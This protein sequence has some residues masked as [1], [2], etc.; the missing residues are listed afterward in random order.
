MLGIKISPSVCAHVFS[1]L[2]W[3]KHD[4]AG[5]KHT[6]TC[7]H[8]QLCLAPRELQD[9]VKLWE[10]PHSKL[11]PGQGGGPE[12]STAFGCL[13][14]D[15][16]KEAGITDGRL[17]LPGSGYLNSNP[18]ICMANAEHSPQQQSCFSWLVWPVS[19]PSHS[20]SPHYI[21]CQSPALYSTVFCTAPH[22]MMTVTVWAIVAI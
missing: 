9:E 1:A 4:I 12:W 2:L 7:E 21:S 13:Q 18:Q 11:L 3:A 22:H 14:P 10:W 19:D 6:V 16:E 8:L 15:S 20:L 17:S 5:I